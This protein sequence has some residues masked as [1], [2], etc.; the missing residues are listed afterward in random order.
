MVPCSRAVGWHCTLV[1]TPLGGRWDLVTFGQHGRCRP[2]VRVR[3]ALVGRKRA[4]IRAPAVASSWGAHVHKVELA[5]RHLV[6]GAAPLGTPH[7]VDDPSVRTVDCADRVVHDVL[8]DV[9]GTRWINSAA[10]LFRRSRGCRAVQ[11]VLRHATRS[12]A[13][14]AQL[15]CSSWYEQE[16]G[17]PLAARRHRPRECVGTRSRR[18]RCAV[19]TDGFIFHRRIRVPAQSSRREAL[20]RIE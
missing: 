8:E 18:R 1:P 19:D 16:H 10:G 20:R 7:S 15:H 11:P 4:V 17:S 6:R 3:S 14:G 13:Q 9:A 12:A 5:D 2:I